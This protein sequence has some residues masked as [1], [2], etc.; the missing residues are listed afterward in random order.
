[1]GGAEKDRRGFSGPGLFVGLLGFEEG[2]REEMI[3]PCRAELVGR[4]LATVALPVGSGG[5]LMAL[6]ACCLGGGTEQAVGCAVVLPAPRHVGADDPPD[7]AAQLY[8]ETPGRLLVA[9][10]AERQAEA[11]LLCSEHGVPLW[12][13]GRTGGKELV[14]RASTAD[15]GWKEVVRLPLALLWQTAGRKPDT[16]L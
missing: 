15:A 11:R 3:E 13:L 10:P 1:L 8:A 16:A 12:P 2:G 9:I 5:L 14:V 7:L 4:G 6:A